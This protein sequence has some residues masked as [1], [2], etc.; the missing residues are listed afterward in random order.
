MSVMVADHARRAYQTSQVQVEDGI[1]LVVQLYDGMIGFLGRGAELLRAQRL[2]EAGAQIRRATDII[3]ELQAVL[4]LD[5][6]GE[7]AFNLDRIYVYCR[8]RIMEGH[9]QNDAA[10]LDEVSRLL[11]P[12]R[13]AWSEAHDKQAE[14]AGAAR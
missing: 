11:A 2:P 9:L 14:L 7:I 8:R 4:D 3:G 1:G 10:A 13:D 6:G 12:L 5:R